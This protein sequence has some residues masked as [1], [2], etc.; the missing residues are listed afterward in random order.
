VSELVPEDRL[1]ERAMEFARLMLEA[2]VAA[3]R[4]G[5]E[6]MVNCQGRDFESSFSVEHDVVFQE[7][8]LKRAAEALV[9]KG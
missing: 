3:L 5:K 1:L 7:F 9:K 2:P 4:Q 8:L 6:F